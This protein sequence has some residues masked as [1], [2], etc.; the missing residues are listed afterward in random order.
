MISI[1]DT[2]RLP[3]GCNIEPKSWYKKKENV[4]ITAFLTPM[5]N[6][7]WGQHSL[8]ALAVFLS[9]PV[10][11]LRFIHSH[12][13]IDTVLAEFYSSSHFVDQIIYN[14]HTVK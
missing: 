11:G 6:Q 7:D 14:I 13:Q 1:L 2:V 4:Y 9:C 8:L 10:P 3:M 5:L 12:E